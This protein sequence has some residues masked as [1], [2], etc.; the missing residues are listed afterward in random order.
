M[1]GWSLLVV[2][3][4]IVWEGREAMRGK[5]CGCSQAR[6]PKDRESGLLLRTSRAVAANFQPR[7]HDPKAAVLLH[8]SFQFLKNVAYELHDLAATQAGHVDVIPIQLALVVVTL[9]VDVH[10]IEFV[11]ET[12]PLQQL[13][14]PV[15]RAAIYA[16]V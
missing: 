15:D 2:L 10:Q 16:R 3:P 4:L 6:Y 12:V 9:A 5:T 14:R 1:R 7:H 8:L 13:Q 11:N